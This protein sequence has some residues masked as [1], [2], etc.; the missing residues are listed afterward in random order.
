MLNI[1]PGYTFDDLLLVPKHSDIKSRQDVDLSVDLGKNVKLEIPIIS[2]NMRSVSGPEMV[3]TIASMG[4]LGVL[5]RFNDQL[6]DHLLNYKKALQKTWDI[7]DDCKHANISF[8]V[9]VQQSDKEIVDIL[10]NEEIGVDD[11]TQIVCV[12]VAH[13]DSTLCASMTE[14][15]AKKYP[16]VLLIAGNVATA[17]GAELLYNSG[18]N[19]IKLNVGNGSLC[20]T[21]IKT[22]NGVPTLT[23]ISD[24][25][26]W[27]IKNNIKDVKLICDGGMRNSGDITKALVFTDAVMLGNLLA[28]TDEAPGDV[29]TTEQGKFKQYAGSST[30]KTN[31]VE[32]VT[33]LTKYKGS[34]KYIIEDLIQGIQSGCS[35]QGVSNLNDLKNEPQFVS[36]SNAGLIESHPHDV[37]V[38]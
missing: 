9:G 23:A 24:I 22:G 26:E 16:E 32:G 29:I 8:S 28:G 6:H 17:S 31:N 38:K 34:V 14:Y 1:T 12:D 10:I 27:R 18:A 2:A 5:H 25:H 33:A 21:R 19:V 20:T 3:A 13:G 30:H 11:L 35:Y 37:L 4:G 15:I 7:W 36:I